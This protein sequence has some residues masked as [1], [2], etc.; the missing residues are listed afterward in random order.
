VAELLI[1]SIRRISF[2]ISP[3]M[4]NDIGLNETLEWL[5]NEFSLLNGI[6]CRF[7]SSYDETGLSKEIELDFFRICQESL[8]N[9]MYHAQ[10]TTVKISIED[11]GDCVELCIMD[12][13]KGFI[14]D[15][16]KKTSG[17]TAIRERTASINGRLTIKSEKGK[18]TKVHVTVAKTV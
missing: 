16:H 18:G 10:A 17:L 1:K 3:D 9:V 4:L 13:G 12:D 14:V 8:N 6:P 11:K 5:C 2:A 7:K 15:E